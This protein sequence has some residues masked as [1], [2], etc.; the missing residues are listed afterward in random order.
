M[1]HV[2]P[3]AKWRI[4]N[5]RSNLSRQKSEGDAAGGRAASVRTHI[6][7]SLLIHRKQTQ[8]KENKRPLS[9]L[10]KSRE[11]EAALF[12]HNEDKTVP[13][14]PNS[15]ISSLRSGLLCRDNDSTNDV[16]VFELAQNSFQ[17]KNDMEEKSYRAMYTSS[18]QGCI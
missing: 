6:K 15:G 1:A 17:V 12:L 11:D 16:F 3:P 4:E 8:G 2:Q 10:N 9:R 14:I 13:I 7:I 18:S 5:H